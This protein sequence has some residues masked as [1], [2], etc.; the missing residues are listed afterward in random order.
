MQADVYGIK[1]V[2]VSQSR[3]SYLALRTSTDH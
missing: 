1:E 2:D 3:K